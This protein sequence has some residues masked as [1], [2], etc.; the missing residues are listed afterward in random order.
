MAHKKR[1]RPRKKES[2]GG[3]RK[4][5]SVM[6]LDEERERLETAR[7]KHGRGIRSLS[8]W[9]GHLALMKLDEL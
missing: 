7:E 4:P 8:A 6:L 2:E 9:L 1:G 5:V 3:V